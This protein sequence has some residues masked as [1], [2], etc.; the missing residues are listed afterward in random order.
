VDQ[1]KAKALVAATFARAR[2]SDSYAFLRRQLVKSQ[3]VLVMYHRVSPEKN[4][5]FL[6][7]SPQ[8]FES[9]IEYFAQNYEILSLDE[10]VQCLLRRESLPRKAIAITFDDGYKDN[11]VYAYPILRKNSVPATI[12]LTT[13]HISTGKPI[14]WDIVKYVVQHARTEVLQMD[15]LGEYSLK[16]GLERSRTLSII[17]EKLDSLPEQ[18]KS[19]FVGQLVETS[20]VHIPIDLGNQLM[21]SWDDVREMSRNEVDFGSHSVTHPRLTSISLNQAMWE[22]RCSKK[23]IEER[24]GETVEFFAYPYGDLNCEIVDLVKKTGFVAA[25]TTDPAWVTPRSNVYQLGRFGVFEDFNMFR[26]TACGLTPDLRS[27]LKLNRT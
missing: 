11:Y 16:S 6:E 3:V 22:I 12:F 4:E 10:I 21:L 7:V 17:I 9:Q 27:I 14:W 26:F 18:E 13:G 8:D 24:L 20:G 23:D 15:E 1:N 25:V 19:L 5:R 2:L